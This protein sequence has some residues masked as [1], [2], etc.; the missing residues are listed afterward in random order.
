[1]SR[2]REKHNF[3]TKSKNETAAGQHSTALC[4]IRLRECA[5][6]GITLQNY[7]LIHSNIFIEIIVTPVPKIL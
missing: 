3:C 5:Q 7:C 1:M 2:G 6:H 4:P